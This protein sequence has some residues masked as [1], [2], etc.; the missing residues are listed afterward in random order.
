VSAFL[1]RVARWWADR[2]LATKGLVVVAVPLLALIAAIVALTVVGRVESRAEQDVRLT[3]VIQ[4]DVHEVH[5]LLAEAASGVRGYLLTGEP[6][7]LSPYLR[8]EAA[9]P[10]VLDRLRGRI[11][12]AQAAE[13]LR[14]IEQL[15][16]RKRA[17]L[18]A[19]REARGAG[20]PAILGRADI[21]RAL[22]ANKAVLD[23]LRLEIAQ[24]QARERQ[25]LAAR[26]ARAEVV[27]R[28]GLIVTAITGLAGLAGS[29]FAVF[30]FSSGI[31][32]RVQRLERDAVLLARG[33]AVA[34]APPA[35][36]EVGQLAARLAE[37]SA[38]LRAREQALR[39]SEERFR[40][41]MEGVRDYGIFTLDPDG[42]ITSWNAGAERIKGWRAD[43]IL[44]R[45]FSAFYPDD[46]RDERPRRNLA[47]AA[48]NGRAE[49]EGWRV[50]KDG[51]RFWANV[52]ITALRDEAD[53][54]R[55]FSKITRDITERRRAEKALDAARLEAEE[56]STAKSVFLSRMSHELRTPLNAILGFAQLLELEGNA[57]PP[58]QRA[59]ADQIL[60][61]GR[62][63][64]TLIDEVL[65]IARIEAG[66]LPLNLEPV[67]LDAVVAE[68][69]SLSG[70]LASGRAVSIEVTD[71]TRTTVLADRRRLLQVL[72]NLLS[73][74]VKYNRDGGRVAVTV[75]QRD[76]EALVAVA[77]TG[78]GVEPAMAGN[79]FR[80]FERLGEA[81]CAAEG[82][83]L[84]LALSRSLLE[85]MGGAIGWEPRPDG[86]PG[87]C[88]WFQ[89]PL[90]A[91]IIAPSRSPE[92]AVPAGFDGRGRTILLIEDN[93]ANAEL[94]EALA[95]RRWP[96]VRLLA[97]MQAR[98][99]LAMAREHQPD[100]VLLDLHLPDESGAWVLDQ[101]RTEMPTVPVLLLTADAPA[102]QADWRT[103][104][105]SAVLTKPVD[106]SA[107]I[108][109]AEELLAK[110]A[111]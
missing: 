78:I 16:A 89:L 71:G 24:M 62:H 76:G 81:A 98:I 43:E 3:I 40:L 66:K 60:R 93:L 25:L 88:F 48:A 86:A 96:D 65:D 36:D 14:R 23:A 108:R 44:G 30:L 61:A 42:I 20:G 28:R 52:V 29:L 73:N 91:E 4:T 79:L 34:P 18:A 6:R 50:R 41:V 37:A 32:R 84:G 2:P 38:L 26:Q 11:R 75:E 67:P 7:F 90:A 51:S 82:T 110:E 104:G 85:A 109:A 45:H 63:L 105:A 54:L 111:A 27:H 13:R 77:D 8:A 97:T 102:A 15:A 49:D 19:L 12:D 31:V 46:Q 35:R 17:G 95:T 57:V 21:L 64:L 47:D 87:A 99:G 92:P 39:D 69:V 94:I 55:G 58:G 59:A 103:R 1:G 106:L 72:L 53:V 22:T 83:G 70:P 80:P 9:L 33:K 101:L 100:L 68:A 107:L 10:T 74:A 5:A 56:A